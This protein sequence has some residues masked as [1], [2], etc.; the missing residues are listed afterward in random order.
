MCT[1]QNLGLWNRTK[2]CHPLNSVN[3]VTPRVVHV[4]MVDDVRWEGV[5]IRSVPPYLQWEATTATPGKT[6]A[7][8]R[9]WVDERLSG[10]ARHLP[11]LR[12]LAQLS[13]TQPALAQWA[14]KR[15]ATRCIDALL[16][17]SSQVGVL[18]LELRQDVS[19]SV[20]RRCFCVC[21]ASGYQCQS[22]SCD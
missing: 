4:T 3:S 15:L 18:R 7:P 17:G 10:L 19:V 6:S 12:P 5:T 13:G 2:L 21:D 11:V 14:S 20:T 9:F 16:R 1:Q 8:T 22:G